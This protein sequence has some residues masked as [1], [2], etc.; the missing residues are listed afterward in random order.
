L[1]LTSKLK[2]EEF[3]SSDEW[4]TRF[5]KK[6]KLEFKTI[7][8]EAKSVDKTK[9]ANFYD[10][11]AKK[12]NEYAP[13]DIWNC[14]ETG[15]VY[16]RIPSKSYVSVNDNCKGEKKLKD[17]ITIMFCCSQTGEKHAPLIIGKS[18]NPRSL[19]NLILKNWV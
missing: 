6:H 16:K 10:T 4:L 8:G 14:D 9:L 18:M 2:V 12:F 17:R 1:K 5:V 3:K 15:L 13:C 7:F 19:K 11:L